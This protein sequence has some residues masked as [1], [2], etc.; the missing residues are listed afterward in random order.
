MN[1]YLE[2]IAEK[3]DHAALT[4]GLVGAASGATGGVI[5][6][7]RIAG[8]IF[9]PIGSAAKDAGLDEIF[10]DHARKALKNV[11]G[12]RVGAYGAIAGLGVG[13]GVGAIAKH[14]MKKDN[15]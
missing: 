10:S 6:G 4:G 9:S 2:K 5:A 15:K 14:L 1:K 7:R 11:M 3:G 8:N 13:A 12:K